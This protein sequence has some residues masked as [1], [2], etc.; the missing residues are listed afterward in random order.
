MHC[1][2]CPE[3]F[4]C[5][6]MEYTKEIRKS[7]SRPSLDWR[8]AVEILTGET[9]DISEYLNFDFYG[10]MKYYNPHIGLAGN[11][12]LGRWLGVAH[13]VG[14]AMSY[15]ILKPN[16]IAHST[17][18]PLTVEEKCSEEENIA[19][20]E[21]MTQL[22]SVVGDFDPDLIST[23]DY[24]INDDLVEPILTTTDDDE[25]QK[26]S[27]PSVADIA[28]GPSSTFGSEFV[29]L[30]IATEMNDALCYKLRVFGVPIDG[31]TN[32]F[33]DNNSV[34]VNVNHPEST[35]NKKHMARYRLLVE[36]T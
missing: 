8:S 26:V 27:Q 16:V 31:P 13:N 21:F 20:K 14:Q 28:Q 3:A 35:L 17:V 7:M 19:K 34:V 9:P 11:V 32:G 10:W 12:F 30:K 36:S 6:G 33:F 15:W 1:V 2:H 22:T 18:W 24:R 5:Y 25:G 29:A 23:D 4:W